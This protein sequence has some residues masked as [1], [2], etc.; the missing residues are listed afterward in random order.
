LRKAAGGG[1]QLSA[2]PAAGRKAR[3]AAK[4]SRRGHRELFAEPRA[5]REEEGSEMTLAVF[6]ILLYQESKEVVFEYKPEPPD[7]SFIW[8]LGI[9]AV[10]LFPL[11]FWWIRR[12]NKS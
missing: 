9:L 8:F 4:K 12:Q 3:K 1:R 5:W 10:V 7:Y 2:K 6:L 11:F